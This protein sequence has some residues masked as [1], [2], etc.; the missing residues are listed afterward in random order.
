MSEGTETPLEVESPPATMPALAVKKRLSPEIQGALIG[1]LATLVAAIVGVVKCN[2]PDTKTIAK[3]ISP[4]E[5][6]NS[7]YQEGADLFTDRSFELARVKLEAAVL[8]AKLS[9]VV[10]PDPMGL[11]GVVQFDKAVYDRS[12]S[13]D[14]EAWKNLKRA[15]DDGCDIAEVRR[16]FAQMMI[17]EGG[18][19]NAVNAEKQYKLALEDAPSNAFDYEGLGEAQRRQEKF[20]EAEENYRKSLD[21][22]PRHSIALIGL[23]KIQAAKGNQQEA[24]A[25]FKEAIELSDRYGQT[26]WRV[27]LGR[28]PE[29]AYLKE[30]P[31]FSYLLSSPPPP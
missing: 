26:D 31:D 19:E 11:L 20:S 25:T 9:K 29:V 15:I 10:A 5:R 18:I 24:L 8:E 6:V 23:A 2:A 16:T 12:N 17:R 7:L 22:D 13:L 3:A 27:V 1:A 4:M 14:Y 30:N 28:D 21:L